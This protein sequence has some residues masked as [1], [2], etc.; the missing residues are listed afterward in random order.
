MVYE[1]HP[2]ALLGSIDSASTHLAEQIVAKANLLLVSPVTSDP[3]VT[4]AGVSWMFACAPSD[5]AIARALVGDLLAVLEGVSGGRIALL[6]TTDHESRMAARECVR[7]LTRRRAAPEYRFEVKPGTAELDAHR[8]AL[9]RAEPDVVI[10]LAGE[11]ESA[12]WV[13]ELRGLSFSTPPLIY[14]GASMARSSFSEL[15]GSAAEGVRFPLPAVLQ[16]DHPDAARFVT[17]FTAQRGY[18]PDYAAL[19]TY[20]ATRFLT[21]AIRRSGPNRVRARAALIELSP[22]S[23][24]A[25]VI[26]FDGTGHNP[27]TDIPVATLRQGRLVLKAPCSNL[28][29]SS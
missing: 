3:S 25:G 11:E 1:E 27:R 28:N 12:R 9:Q 5:A 23:G 22:W 14:G 13:R 4:L 16:S 10:I 19:L 26:R 18:A 24:L 21:A 6:N 2:V 7:E 15:A 29:R 20:D 17:A 8:A